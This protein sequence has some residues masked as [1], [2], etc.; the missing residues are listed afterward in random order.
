[1][2]IYT[3]TVLFEY[4]IAARL[5]FLW[6]TQFVLIYLCATQNIG[7]GFV[8]IVASLAGLQNLQFVYDVYMIKII[9]WA[10]AILHKIRNDC[11]NCFHGANE[12]RNKKKFTA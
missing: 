6:L 11:V 8:Y 5:L 2:I 3:Y 4:F 10:F 1:M 12:N 7:T 9:L